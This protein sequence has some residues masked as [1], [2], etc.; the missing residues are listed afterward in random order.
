VEQGY[1]R[2]A[3]VVQVYKGSGGVGVQEYYR[4]TG[5]VQYVRSSTCLHGSV[6]EA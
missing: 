3:G 1:Y 2:C 5:Y 6:V 4:S